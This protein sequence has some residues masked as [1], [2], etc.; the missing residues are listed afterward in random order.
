MTSARDDI[1]G[2]IRRSLGVRGDERTRRSIV[3]ERIERAPRGVIP[4]RGQVDGE[5][6]IALFV[7]QATAAHATISQVTDPSQVPAAVADYLRSHNLP[8]DLRMAGDPRLEGMPWAETSLEIREGASDGG[9]LTGLSHAFGGVAE[10]GTLVLVSGPDNPSTLNFL[11]DNHLVVLR[12]EDI[13]GD[14]EDVWSRI[15]FAY[16]KG[17]MPRTVNYITGPSRSA[18]IEQTLLL[19]AHGPR[20]LHIVLVGEQP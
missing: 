17:E 1:L 4:A 13:A 11:P 14:Y 8:A 19:G 9:D 12:A 2:T 6:R 16:G 10:T 18:D 20:R 7:A 5:E 3:E 15:R